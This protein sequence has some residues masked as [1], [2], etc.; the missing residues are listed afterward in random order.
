MGAIIN[1][2]SLMDDCKESLAR[3]N[4]VIYLNLY[5]NWK[6]IDS[7]PELTLVRELPMS[8]VYSVNARVLL[9]WLRGV[10]DWQDIIITTETRLEALRKAWVDSCMT[11]QLVKEWSGDVS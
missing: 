1:K 5:N 9:T 6:V 4:R 10:P 8:R 3:G 7:F 2:H 11:E